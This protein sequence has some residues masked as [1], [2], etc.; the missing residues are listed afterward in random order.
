M[1]TITEN[2]KFRQAKYPQLKKLPNGVRLVV[3]DGHELKTGIKKYCTLL[4]S[5]NL[6]LIG[7]GN[8]KKSARRNS[9]EELNRKLRMENLIWGNSCDKNNYLKVIA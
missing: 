7:A 9:L 6:I 3:Q 4:K 8:S 1:Q 5:G 2:L